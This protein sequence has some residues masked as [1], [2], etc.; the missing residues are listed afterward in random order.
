MKKNAI[1]GLIRKLNEFRMSNVGKTLVGSELRES[2]MALGFSKA[3]ASGIAQKAFPYEQMGKNRLYEVPKE[4]IHKNV[5]IA[6]NKRANDYTKK[7]SH[8]DKETPRTDSPLTQQKA[9]DTLVEAGIIKAK[10][11]LNTLKAKYPKVYLECLEYELVNPN[12]K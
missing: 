6:L 8:N 2:L 10:F 7:S 9:W 1:D 4:P 5:L 11:N 3:E 12:N